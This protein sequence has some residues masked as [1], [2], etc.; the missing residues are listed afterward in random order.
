M[1]TT[2]GIILSALMLIAGGVFLYQAWAYRKKHKKIVLELADEA[3]KLIDRMKRNKKLLPAEAAEEEDA[4]DISGYA[5]LASKFN[6]AKYLST[7]VT[8]LV[9]KAGGK[10]RLT[11]DDFLDVTGDEYISI[12]VD[13]SDNAIILFLNTPQSSFYED[14]ED[15]IVYN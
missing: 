3:S 4:D 12:Y 5:S 15:E 14:E 13:T 6:S 11:E 7:L 9:K 8:V 1:T 10:V 2:T